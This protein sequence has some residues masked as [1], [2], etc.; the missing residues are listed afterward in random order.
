MTHNNDPNKKPCRNC[1]K[2]MPIVNPY[3]YSCGTVQKTGEIERAFNA[4]KIPLTGNLTFGGSV[5]KEEGLR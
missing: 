5:S 2:P 1:G 4:K 3:C